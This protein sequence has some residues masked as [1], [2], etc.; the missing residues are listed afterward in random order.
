MSIVSQ[1]HSELYKPA[2]YQKILDVMSRRILEARKESG[3]EA[4]AFRGSSGA[5]LAFPLSAR[6]GIPLLH[7]RKPGSHC[8]Y[9]VEGDYKVSRYAIVDDFVETGETLR[10]IVRSIKEAFTERHCP[11]PTLTDVFLYRMYDFDENPDYFE[12]E[13]SPPQG[14]LYHGLASECR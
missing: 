9:I 14:V 3:F 2:V 8:G 13:L 10:T 12:S 7:S 5:A 6:L 1:Y 11:I 4:L